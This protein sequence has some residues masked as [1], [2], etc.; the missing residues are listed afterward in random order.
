MDRSL[1][2]Q[3]VADSFGCDNCI[4]EDDGRWHDYCQNCNPD[5]YPPSK[6]CPARGTIQEK[7]YF[8][9]TNSITD[10]EIARFLNTGK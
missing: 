8:G 6:Y 4:H 3:N 1:M 10:S 9:K 5:Y 7:V 2:I